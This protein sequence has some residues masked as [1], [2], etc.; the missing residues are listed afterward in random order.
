MGIAITSTA[1]K[2]IGSTIGMNR[3]AETSPYQKSWVA[4]Q[5]NDLVQARAAIKARDFESLAEVSE[6]S[7]L[8]MHA[9]AMSARPGLIYWNGATVE[10]M[11]C[12]RALR[13]QG[14][15]VFFTVD[16]GPQLK[17]VCLP[18]A[19]P[20]VSAALRGLSGVLDVVETGL[21]AGARVLEPGELK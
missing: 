21:G 20:K 2:E 19:L 14:V 5:E 13:A 12:A 3:T 16:A 11:R 6:H 18:E 17:A 9:L 10:G 4:S 7:C 1:A 15:A 8:K